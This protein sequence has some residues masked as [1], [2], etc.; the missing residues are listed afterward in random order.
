MRRRVDQLKCLAIVFAISLVLPSGSASAR[1][2]ATPEAAPPPS[3]TE[4]VK[5]AEYCPDS[6]ELAVLGLINDY[7][8]S[9]GLKPLRLS[10]MLGAAAESH[11][12]DM[13]Q[14]DYFSHDLADGRTWAEN[15][16]DSGYDSSTPIGENIAA[17]YSS[18]EEV[19]AQWIKSD[20][21]RENML[22]DRFA[23]IGIARAHNADSTYGWYWTTT[24]GGADDAEPSC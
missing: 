8:I 14:N 21:H 10:R 5:P 12:R 11:S 19:F 22:S 3:V 9:E 15:I 6:Q 1:R 18:A 2:S 20:T 23:S 17:G 7:R 24:F 13:A 4:E 16:L